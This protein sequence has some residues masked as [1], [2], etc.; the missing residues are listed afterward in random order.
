[1]IS[2]L[3]KKMDILP[4]HQARGAAG[5]DGRDGAALQAHA[6]THACTHALV[7]AAKL[8]QAVFFLS[9]H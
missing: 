9:A 8:M 1:M 2:I 3:G 5:E 7:G 6:W 4:G